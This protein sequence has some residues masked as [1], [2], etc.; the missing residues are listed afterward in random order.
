MTLRQKLRRIDWVGN[1]LVIAGTA[2][3]LYALT[4]AGVIHSWASW[5]T[6]LPLLLGLLGLILFA[7]WEARGGGLSPDLVMPPRLFHHRTSLIIAICTFFHWMLVYWSLYFL[8]VWF[9]AVFLYSAECTGVGI[10]PLSLVTIPG[11]A[12]S[13]MAVTLQLRNGCFCAIGAAMGLDTLLPAFQAP[14]PESDQ[15]AATSTC[16]FIRTVGGV[17]G[18]AVP[19]AIFNNRINQ[20]AYTIS[21]PNT[22]RLMMGGDGYQHASA[23][24][25]NSF[26]E[27]VYKEALQL[28]FLT[29]VAFGDGVAVLFLLEKDV[30]LWKELETEYGL[31]EQGQ[32]QKEANGNRSVE[33][34]PPE[35]SS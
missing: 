6:L 4:G 14:V 19:A 21:D 8:P 25:V 35:T 22:R 15:A 1:T 13:A 11:S 30:S 3:M 9:Q 10:L 12:I 31:V 16:T 33:K 27:P 29:A 28:V 23:D 5:N 32:K 20:L 26:P 24:F 18:V 2:A 7:A 34:R 17:W